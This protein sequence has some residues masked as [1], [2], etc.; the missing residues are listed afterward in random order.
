[1]KIFINNINIGQT[2]MS[3]LLTNINIM[4]IGQTKMSVLPNVISIF[5]NLLLVY[6]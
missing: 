5:I 6:P 3:V 2:G 1:M 4:I